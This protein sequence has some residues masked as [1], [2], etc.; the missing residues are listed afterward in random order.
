MKVFDFDNTIYD[1]ECCIDFFLF[2]FRKKRT[3]SRY[4]PLAV[5]SLVLYKLNKL[6]ISKVEEVAD[7]LSHVLVKY[8][9]EA[10]NLIQEFWKTHQHKLKDKILDK[11]GEDDIIITASP[12]VLIDGIKDKL[13][14]NNVVCS[15]LDVNTGKLSFLCMGENKVKAFKELYPNISID[16]FYTDSM[17]DKPLIDIADNAFFVKGKNIIQIK[18]EE[19][20]I[21]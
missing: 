19:K 17:S 16:E 13:R 5:Y 11:I 18:G 4:I 1:G 8:K 15:K 6:P 12:G 2:A 7:S 3:F 9:D 10:S 14:T 20:K 21:R